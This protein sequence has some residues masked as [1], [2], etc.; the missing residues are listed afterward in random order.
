MWRPW[1]TT[2]AKA[3]SSWFD[4][5]IYE[6]AGKRVIVLICYE[7]LLIW[8]ILYSMF[9]KPDIIISSSNVWWA[10][11]TNI[12]AIQKEAVKDWGKII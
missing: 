3:R 6:L 7:Q 1:S 12:P 5:V 4:P 10:K 2:K 8:P 9:Y 11:D